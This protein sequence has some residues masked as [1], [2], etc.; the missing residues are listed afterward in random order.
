M[1]SCNFG[2]GILS[3][4]NSSTSSIHFRGWMVSF[5][6][7]LSGI[8]LSSLSFSEGIITWLIPPRCAARSFS[9]NPPNGPHR[10]LVP[11]ELIND[12]QARLDRVADD[13]VPPGGTHT[14]VWPV[15]ERTGPAEND[16]NSVFWMHHSHTDENK[17]VNRA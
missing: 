13:A 7:T 9:F 2:S 15:P 3:K 1:S 10:L 6:L 4:A 17:D 8:S 11:T 16:A 5:S 12:G 14:Y